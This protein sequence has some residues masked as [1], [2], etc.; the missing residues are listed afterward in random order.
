M[1][2][3]SK[4]EE[5]GYGKILEAWLCPEDAGDPVGCLATTYTFNSVFFEEECLSRFVGLDSDPET[6]AT[7]YVIEQEIRLSQLQAAAVLADQEHCAGSRSLRWDLLPGRPPNG[8]LHAK[9]CL[10]VWTNQVRLILS[11]A[12]LSRTATGT[13]KKCSEYSTTSEGQAPLD[14]LLETVGFLRRCADSLC[15]QDSKWEPL[16]CPLARPI[17]PRY[18]GAVDLGHFRE[19]QSRRPLRI[20]PASQERA[21]SAMSRQAHR[22]LAGS[23]SART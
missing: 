9:I 22:V 16:T 20:Y 12:N 6:D 1:A 17:G 3:K 23:Y 2:R 8:L 10:L 19:Q 18:E 13:T 21:W 11:S 4:S 5:R 14:G 7:A 15:R